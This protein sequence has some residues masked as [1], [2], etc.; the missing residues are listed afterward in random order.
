MRIIFVTNNYTPYSGGVVSS[1]QAMVDGLHAQGH[2]VFIITL[3]FLGAAHN[4][5]D[6]VIRITSPVRFYY[7]K[8]H[9]AIPWRPAY[10]I[11]QLVRSYMPDI[12]HVHHPFLLGV[13]GMQAA[14]SIDVPCVFT[15][16]TLYEHYAHYIPLPIVVSRPLIKKM[17]R[18][19]AL[20]VDSIVVPS[21][22]IKHDLRSQGVLSPIEV[23]P[24]PLRSSF[25]LSSGITRFMGEKQFFEL[26][27]VSRFVPEK[28]ISFVFDVF[29]KLPSCVRLTL[30][31]YGTEYEKMQQLA[32]DEM[33]FSRE[34]VRF[35]HKPIQ[36]NLV[37]A[38]RSSDLFIF[39]S[40]TDTQGLVMVEAMSQGLPVIAVDGPGQR[41]IVQ[42]G[43][44]GFIINNACHAANLILDIMNNVVLYNSLVAGAYATSQKYTPDCTVAKLVDFYQSV[45]P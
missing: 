8:N 27:V 21:T 9:M 20:S 35:I 5:P 3:D 40:Q 22:T 25:L 10:S 45:T 33:H 32:F 24:S 30:V 26:L 37:A 41:D 13:G 11:M 34:R 2:E 29:K 28:N 1:I 17:V 12:V 18:D 38:Y 4:D 23:I 42:N 31:G 14:R 19:F 43:V 36:D 6:Y 39:S 7:K 16:H 15:Y 44:N